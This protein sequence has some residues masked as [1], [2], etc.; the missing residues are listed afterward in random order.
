MILFVKILTVTALLL[1][2]MRTNHWEI[3][4]SEVD[5]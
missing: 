1:L 4:E 2:V 5:E 3:E